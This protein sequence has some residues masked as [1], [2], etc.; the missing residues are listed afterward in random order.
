MNFDR[1]IRRIFAKR[2]LFDEAE[3]REVVRPTID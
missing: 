1:K 2:H 3:E